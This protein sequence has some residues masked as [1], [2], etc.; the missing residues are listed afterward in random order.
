MPAVTPTPHDAALAPAKPPRDGLRRKSLALLLLLA[1]T[2]AGVARVLGNPPPI[3]AAGAVACSHLSWSSVA[4]ALLPKPLG[5]TGDIGTIALRGWQCAEAYHV[6]SPSHVLVAMS[7]LYVGLQAFAIPG[8]LVLSIVSGAVFGVWRGQ[9]LVAVWATS[10]ATLCYLLSATLA[11]PLI[12]RCLP[13]RLADMQA[14]IAPV[15]A[16]PHRLFWYMLAMRITPVCPNWLVNLASPLIG[17]PLHVFVAATL[18]GLLPAN[19]FHCSTGA[20]L[21]A[22]TSAAAAA[23]G[24]S[25][26]AA[27]G[28]GAV[29]EA[30]TPA[31]ADAAVVGG[32]ASTSAG[33]EQWG[34]YIAAEGGHALLSLLLLQVLALVPPWLMRRQEAQQ[35]QRQADGQAAASPPLSS[36]ER[37]GGSGSDGQLADGA[38][39]VPL[40]ATASGAEAK[41]ASSGGEEAP[42]SA[43]ARRRP[44]RGA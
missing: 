16:H 30:S 7:A 20:A 40:E 4:A 39:A 10:G 36:V 41:P 21:R 15:V 38:G 18:V 26:V 6:E 29:S 17:V 11:E 8:P 35:Q 12:R 34:A 14:R 5:G 23:G 42:S 44:R 33:G 27:G 31:A 37:N 32:S 22:I 13:G 3:P 25:T 1:A 9:A 24:M 19:Y 2:V 43:S 28:S